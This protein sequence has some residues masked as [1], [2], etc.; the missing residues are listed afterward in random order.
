MGVRRQWLVILTITLFATTPAAAVTIHKLEITRS[1]DSYLVTF[2]VLVA[3]DPAKARELLSD[4][5]QWPRL[6][7][8]L[9]ESRLLKTFADERQRV[10]LRFRTCVLIFCKTIHQVKD[11]E[12]RPN[13]DIVT[14]MVPEDSDFASGWERWQILAEGEKTRVRYHAEIVPGFGVPPLIGP[15]ILKRKLRRTLI[16]TAKTLEILAIR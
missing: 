12:N 10:R 7:K 15:W 4:Y 13:S 9:K 11:V 5:R 6:S 8:T 16:R 2:D 1:Q 3:A 14:V